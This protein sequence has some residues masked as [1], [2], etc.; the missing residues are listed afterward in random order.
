MP[1]LKRKKNK[2]ERL[3]VDVDLLE[4]NLKLKIFDLEEIKFD[5]EVS[6]V[7]TFNSFG[8]L[9]VLPGHINFITLI[10]KEI[11][12]KK[13]NNEVIK[14]EIDSGVIRVY[15]NIVEIYLGLDLEKINKAGE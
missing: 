14:M 4:E 3:G 8:S 1:F 5:G 13:I 15:K 2:L 9:D 11:L 6:S 7:S 10:Q 12:I